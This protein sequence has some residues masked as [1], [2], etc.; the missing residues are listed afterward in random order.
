QTVLLEKHFGACRFV[1]NYFLELRTKYYAENKDKKNAK[2]SLTA[3]DTMKMLTEL[4]K[5]KEW[6]YE[7]NSQSLQRSLVKL[8]MAFKSFFKHNTD[9]PTFH[10]KKDNQYFIVP[11]TF[12]ANGNR[13]I[14]LKV[15]G[16]H[17]IQG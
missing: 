1:W 17:R 6:L 2:K 12:K 7:I 10:S 5:E 11:A 14:I 8:D 4:K 9:Y 13:L 15:S 16:R 3:F